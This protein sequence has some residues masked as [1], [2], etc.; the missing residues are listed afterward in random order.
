MG[1]ME[2]VKQKTAEE[3]LY[4]EWSSD[5]GSSDLNGTG[6]THLVG[7]SPFNS[8]GSRRSEGFV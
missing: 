1:A 2:C 6:P 3:M 4:R 7:S 5:V 8:A